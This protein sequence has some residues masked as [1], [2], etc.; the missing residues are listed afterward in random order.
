MST[1]ELNAYDRSNRLRDPDDSPHLPS[2]HHA[3]MLRY[4]GTKD[5][6]Y[7]GKW[8][9]FFNGDTEEEPPPRGYATGENQ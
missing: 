1:G 5:L 4:G 7:L 8:L 9:D 6:A 2:E 3:S